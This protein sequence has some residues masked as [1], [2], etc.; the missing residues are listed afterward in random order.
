MSKAGERV[1]ARLN[2]S[3]PQKGP[4]APPWGPYPHIPEAPAQELVAE[5]YRWR[6]V[7]APRAWRPHE[8]G[9]RIVGVFIGCSQ[10]SGEFGAYSVVV[11]RTADG[12]MSV[13]G[14]VINDLVAAAGLVEGEA[15]LVIY[16]GAH[17]SRVEGHNPW[18]DF[19]M[20]KAEG[21]PNTA[22]ER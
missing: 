14:K 12:P 6:K 22:P 17:P 19:E 3:Y 10:R 7:T 16:K 2:K 11:L 13:S 4:Q 9:E 21:V 5:G 1:R 8:V 18:K 20:F 15:V